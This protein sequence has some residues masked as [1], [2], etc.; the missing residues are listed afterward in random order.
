MKEYKEGFY[1]L[2]SPSEPEP[3]LVHGYFCSDLDGEFVFGFNTYDGG[4]LIKLPEISDD[5]EIKPIFINKKDVIAKLKELVNVQ[6]SDGNWNYDSYMHGMANGMI[7]S[8]SVVE[9]SK[10][11]PKYLEDPDEYIRNENIPQAMKNL[12][13]AIQNDPDYAWSWLCNIAVSAQ[14]EGIEYSAS[15]RSAARFMQTAFAIDMTAHE[16]FPSTQINSRD[17]IYEETVALAV[18][19]W[20][21]HYSEISPNWKPLDTTLGVLSQIDNMLTGI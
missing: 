2:T 4:G 11:A 9:D 14:D 10:E 7:F 20:S 1:Y 8:L 3:I 5:T 13:E 19:L 18:S 17:E 12:A 21:K 6:C 16:R 15:N